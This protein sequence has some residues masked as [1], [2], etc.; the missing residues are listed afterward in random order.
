VYLRTVT[1]PTGPVNGSIAP[2]IVLTCARMTACSAVRSD[3]PLGALRLVHRAV[4]WE[5]PSTIPTAVCGRC[6]SG[7]FAV[8]FVGRFAVPV[9]GGLSDRRRN[10][11][12]SA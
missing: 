8:R 11:D 6:R 7:P 10:H 9:S 5:V 1:A 2:A 12:W 4:A 3:A